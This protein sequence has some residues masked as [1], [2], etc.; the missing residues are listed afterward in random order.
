[1][2]L[3][4]PELDPGWEIAVSQAFGWVPDGKGLA[5]LREHGVEKLLDATT[6]AEGLA[7]YWPLVAYL[8]RTLRLSDQRATAEGASHE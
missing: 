6:G 2:E 7:E 1:L 4:P 3:N 5:S 8:T